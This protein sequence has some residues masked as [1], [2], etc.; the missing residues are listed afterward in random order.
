MSSPLEHLQRLR[1]LVATGATDYAARLYFTFLRCPNLEV[2]LLAAGLMASSIKLPPRVLRLLA[3]PAGISGTAI[4]LY[5][6]AT[7]LIANLR[8]P[9]VPRSTLPLP[10]E[11]VLDV[12]HRL[13]PEPVVA[14]AMTSRFNYSSYFPK[15]RTPA[16]RDWWS[17]HEFV[18][19]LARDLPH[20][21]KPREGNA[22]FFHFVLDCEAA[23]C[24][25]ASKTVAIVLAST[26]SP[27]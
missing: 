1:T 15:I 4:L 5:E 23:A 9:E 16:L 20:L 27:A 17:R 25:D 2:V 22:V 14:F 8:P 19:L 7:R 21:F 18:G 12:L 24:T 6:A 11:L 10:T 13:P 26:S 3:V